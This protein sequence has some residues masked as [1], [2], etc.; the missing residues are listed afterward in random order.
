MS[1]CSNIEEVMEAA[2]LAEATTDQTPTT[3]DRLLLQQLAGQVNAIQ[4]AVGKMS[5]AAT[6]SVTTGEAV[7]NVNAVG[8]NASTSIRNALTI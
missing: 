5:A 1:R 7:V 2:R 3:A 6:T 8:T 4:E